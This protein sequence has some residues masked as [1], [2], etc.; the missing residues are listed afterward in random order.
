[1]QNRD[2]EAYVVAMNALCGMFRV[3]PSEP[4]LDGYWM[5]LQD[6]S[7]DDVRAAV[8]KAA[9]TCQF[10]PPAAE[11]RKL[12]GAGAEQA[13]IDAW[14][15]VVNAIRKFGAYESVDFGPT[16]NAA[17]RAVGGWRRLCTA[18]SA[19]LHAFIRREF[20]QALEALSAVAE[21]SLDGAPLVGQ[22]RTP[23]VRIAIRPRD[24]VPL[25]ESVKAGLLLPAKGK[26]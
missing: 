16:V 4:F 8:V 9:R 14:N 17:V 6:V 25:L 3:E 12:A 7:I 5:A 1:M 20:A 18:D 13:S 2:R 10:M 22:H 15:G 21:A 11:L 24:V 19:E 26:P 23:P